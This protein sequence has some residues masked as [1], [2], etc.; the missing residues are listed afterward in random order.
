MNIQQIIL[1]LL[2]TRLTTAL[3]RVK[4]A[5]QLNRLNDRGCEIQEYFQARAS[6]RL[7]EKGISPKDEKTA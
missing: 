1:N 2:K 3:H 4:I 6:T 5:L 7:K